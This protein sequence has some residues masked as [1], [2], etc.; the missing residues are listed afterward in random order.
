MDLYIFLTHFQQGTSSPCNQTIRHLISNLPW[1]P[2]GRPHV[3]Y[4]GSRWPSVGA[5]AVGEV[6]V[7]ASAP[8]RRVCGRSSCGFLLLGSAA[9]SSC[10]VVGCSKLPGNKPDML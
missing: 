2:R 3:S 8:G 1:Q 10:N 6:D 5:A 4:S 9:R 7:A